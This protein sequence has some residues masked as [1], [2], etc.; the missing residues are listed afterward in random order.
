M[1]LTFEPARWRTTL[2]L[3]EQTTPQPDTLRGPHWVKDSFFKA[4]RAE[5][6]QKLF[7]LNNTLLSPT[8]LAAIGASGLV[9]FANARQP[10]V[11][12]QLGLGRRVA[13]TAKRG[14]DHV[15]F[16]RWPAD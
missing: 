15:L 10:S 7:I 5:Y 12:A 13:G 4:Y 11:N 16:L 1:Q 9:G 3:D 14:K 8:N 6:K 2:A